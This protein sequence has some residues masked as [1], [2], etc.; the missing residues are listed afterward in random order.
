MLPHSL[1]IHV[2][3]PLLD[4]TLISF[5]PCLVAGGVTV[6]AAFVT[7]VLLLVGAAPVVLVVLTLLAAFVV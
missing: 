5:G 3:W 1:G 7:F 6:E 2:T 4:T